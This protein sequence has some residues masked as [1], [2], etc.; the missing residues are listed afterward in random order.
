MAGFMAGML[1]LDLMVF[2]RYLF[3]ARLPGIPL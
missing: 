2:V 3:D 1:F